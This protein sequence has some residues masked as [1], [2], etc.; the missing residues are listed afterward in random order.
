MNDITDSDY[1]FMFFL[2]NSKRWKVKRER[3]VP[4]AAEERRRR[5]DA[6]TDVLRRINETHQGSET[7]TERTGKA[8]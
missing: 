1:A 2:L 4:D 8:A 7:S 6:E 3:F 5:Y